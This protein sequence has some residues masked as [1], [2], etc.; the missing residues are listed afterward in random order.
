MPV[1]PGAGT[2]YYT[3]LLQRN[4][5]VSGAGGRD[6]VQGGGGVYK[7]KNKIVKGILSK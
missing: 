7:I 1:V 5:T 3:A 2:V 6:G 4:L